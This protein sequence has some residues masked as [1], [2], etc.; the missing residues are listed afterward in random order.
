M[1][2]QS[3]KVSSLNIHADIINDSLVNKNDTKH[4]FIRAHKTDK[5]NREGVLYLRVGMAVKR[6]RDT[7]RIN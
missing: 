3:H 7:G 1:M 2:S 4:S 6:P 5:A